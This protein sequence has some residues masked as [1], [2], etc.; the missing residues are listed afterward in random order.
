MKRN[1]PNYWEKHKEI[2]TKLYQELDKEIAERISNDPEGEDAK[3]L[4]WRVEQ[5][6]EEVE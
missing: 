5:E 3:Y 1:D 4:N 2:Y 6:I